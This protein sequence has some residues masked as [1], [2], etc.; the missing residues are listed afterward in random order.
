MNMIR[1]TKPK[2][3]PKYHDLRTDFKELQ[4]QREAKSPEV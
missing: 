1:E 2:S 3:L 4:K